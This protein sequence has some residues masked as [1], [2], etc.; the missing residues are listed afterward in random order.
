VREYVA[1]NIPVYVLDRNVPLIQRFLQAPRTKYPDS[2][3]RTSTEPQLRPVTAK[4]TI[5][6]GANRLELYPL[7][8]ETT[9]RQIMVYFPDHKLLYG[10]DCFQKMQDGT[11]FYPQTMYELKNAVD[12]EHLSVERYFMMHIP[13][14]P[15]SEVLK[16]VQN[17]S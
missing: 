2:L 8:G 14:S 9:E 17:A 4:T 3:A 12:R 1:Q 10:S 11:F 7:H 16:T 5:G 13:P 15:W 6:T